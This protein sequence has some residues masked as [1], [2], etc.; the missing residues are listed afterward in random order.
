MEKT[1]LP[2]NASSVM[3]HSSI[4]VSAS[5]VIPVLPIRLWIPLSLGRNFRLSDIKK[6]RNSQ[7][8][9]MGE[10]SC[11]IFS[12]NEPTLL[13]AGHY[14]DPCIGPVQLG[15]TVALMLRNISASSSDFAGHLECW[16]DHDF[17]KLKRLDRRLRPKGSDE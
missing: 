14:P 17:E 11:E 12:E 8:A 15:W 16:M 5:P 1:I 2:F 6:G 9:N 13:E 3:G 4:I 7:F 10:I